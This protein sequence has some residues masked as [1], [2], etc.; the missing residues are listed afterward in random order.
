M[1]EQEESSEEEEDEESEET[2]DGF[3]SFSSDADDEDDEEWK[4]KQFSL[5]IIFTLSYNMCSCLLKF[6]DDVYSIAF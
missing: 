1:K 6:D 5:C 3:G 2:D 4:Q